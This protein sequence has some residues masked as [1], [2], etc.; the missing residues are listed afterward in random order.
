M[1]RT[2]RT[3]SA[4][5]KLSWLG[6]TPIVIA[7]SM[8]V[9]ETGTLGFT[10]NWLPTKQ[11]TRNYRPPHGADC[12]FQ[13]VRAARSLSGIQCSMTANLEGHCASSSRKGSTP[14]LFLTGGIF[15]VSTFAGSTQPWTWNYAWRLKHR[16]SVGIDSRC[17]RFRNVLRRY[18]SSNVCTEITSL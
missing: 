10:P 12:H 7:D 16:V 5:P 3:A 11:G 2:Q 8:N 18:E 6:D 4:L 1:S 17:Q 9:L 15:L 14:A 13:M